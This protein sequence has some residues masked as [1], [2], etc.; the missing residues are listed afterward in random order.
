MKIAIW[1]TGKTAM[2]FIKN[3]DLSK[4][5]IVYFIDND[6]KKYN[7][8]IFNDILCILPEMVKEDQYDLIC[9]CSVYYNEIILQC[10]DLKLSN[11]FIMKDIKKYPVLKKLIKKDEFT[12]SWIEENIIMI[13]NN[14]DEMMWRNTFIDTVSGYEWWKNISISPGRFAVGYNYLYVMARSLSAISPSSILEFGLGQS[15][16]LL[17]LYSNFYKVHYDIIEQDK[18]WINFFGLE[19]VLGNTITV[20]HRNI[21]TFYDKEGGIRYKYEEIDSIVSNMKYNIISIDGPWGG[22]NYSRT[23]IIDFLPKILDTRFLIIIDD[24][25]RIGEKRTINMIQKKL[26]SNNIDYNIKVYNG[27]K[28]ICIIVSS[29]LKFLTTL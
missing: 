25:N 18:A 8:K 5:E 22:E 16:K 4:N 1:G 27:A 14:M 2:K 3:L 9:I 28:E 21:D 7:Q 26:K 23:D 13:K 19:N 24:Y 17:S 20:H 29:D 10:E 11:Y 15:S 6:K 12:A